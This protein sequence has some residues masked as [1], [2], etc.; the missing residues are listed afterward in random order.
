MSCNKEILKRGRA[1]SET[2]KRKLHY[3]DEKRRR[4]KHSPLKRTKGKMSITHESKA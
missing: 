4:G 3:V 1:G 2:E